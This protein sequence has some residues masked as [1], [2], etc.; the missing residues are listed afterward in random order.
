LL[1]QKMQNLGHE[2]ILMLDA[3]METFA[4]LDNL[5]SSLKIN[6]A[7]V[8]PH[9]LTP[10]PDDGKRLTPEQLTLFG[11]Y[12]AG[13]TG[14]SNRKPA[15][16]FVDWWLQISLE[17]GEQAPTQGRYAEQGWLRF[18]VD[19][20]DWVHICRDPGIN[21]AWWRID[22]PEQVKRVCDG[23]LVD[24]VPLKLFHFSQIDFDDLKSITLHQ[25]RL[26]GSGDLLILYEEYRDK[27]KNPVRSIVPD[28]LNIGNGEH[29]DDRTQA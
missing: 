9:R 2:R 20:M 7:I 16:D 25:D 6:D 19:F 1:I 14:W 27:V 18:A 11:N 15:R 4:P 29:A 8:T 10:L 28:D 17:A 21:A 23:W 12:N 26:R 22:F 5:F 24:G 13:F 3:D